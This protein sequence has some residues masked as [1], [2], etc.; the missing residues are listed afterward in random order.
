M[1]LL[2]AMAQGAVPVCTEVGGM[3]EVVTHGHDGLLV[4]S[5]D[6]RG[7]AE[8]LRK[9]MG[10]GKT[11]LEMKENARITVEERFNVERT[12]RSLVQYY[13]SLM[14]PDPFVGMQVSSP[15]NSL[16]TEGA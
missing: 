7:F 16:G 15:T 10:R 1:A 2:E 12:V 9:L 11:Y 4:P 14:D 3:K 8:A 6:S 5:G 13:W